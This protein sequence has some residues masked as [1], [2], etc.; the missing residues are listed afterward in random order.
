M[1]S[2]AEA[3]YGGGT[4]SSFCL[5]DVVTEI[6]TLLDV[7]IEE[8]RITVQQD[9]GQNANGIISGDRSLVRVALLNVLHNAVKFSDADSVLSIRYQ[10]TLSVGG[11]FKQICIEN[12]GPVSR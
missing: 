12:T 10:R 5:A 3:T 7:V 6:L 9:H 8:R 2:K 4:T 11:Y 1:L